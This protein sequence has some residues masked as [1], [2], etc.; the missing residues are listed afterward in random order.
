MAFMNYFDSA[1]SNRTNTVVHYIFN[2]NNL[3]FCLRTMSD[4][5]YTAQVGCSIFHTANFEQ[6]ITHQHEPLRKS[7]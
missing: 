7:Y 5:I 6:T 4:T 3:C 1:M 2:G